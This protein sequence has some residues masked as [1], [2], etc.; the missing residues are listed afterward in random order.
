PPDVQTYNDPKFQSTEQRD[1]KV[2]PKVQAGVMVAADFIYQAKKTFFK[3][4]KETPASKN[5]LNWGLG[6][7]SDGLESHKEENGN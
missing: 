1:A 7:V 2:F 5:Q 3:S 6:G 4:E